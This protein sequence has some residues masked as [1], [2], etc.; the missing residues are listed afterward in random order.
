MNLPASD[1]WL[2]PGHAVRLDVLGEVLVP[3][4]AL[5]NGATIVQEEVDSVTYW[6]VELDSHDILIANGMPAES[7]IDVGNRAFFTDGTGS[8]DG[9]ALT[10]EDYCR[11]L[12]QDAQIIAVMRTRLLARAA[13]MGWSLKAI[14]DLDIHLVADGAIVRPDIKGTLAR[15]VVTADVREVW[16]VSKTF[17]PALIGMNDDARHLGLQVRSI[18]ID[19]GLSPRGE[20]DM[21]DPSFCLGFH[22]LETRED[23]STF[24]WTAGRSLLQAELWEGRTGTMFLQVAFNLLPHHAWMLGDAKVRDVSRSQNASRPSLQ[25]VHAA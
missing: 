5:I 11:P 18:G 21:A 10:L 20:T 25:L 15:F 6:H 9:V 22:A 14:D 24:R 3:I 12:I 8:P 19:D 7:Y 1:L 13:A 2:S 17:V 16:L 23:G 4:G